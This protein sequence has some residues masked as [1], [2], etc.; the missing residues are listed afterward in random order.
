MVCGGK[1]VISQ[2]AGA[3]RKVVRAKGDPPFRVAPGDHLVHGLTGDD[4]VKM[5]DRRPL[6][7]DLD[8]EKPLHEPRAGEPGDPL[9]RIDIYRGQVVRAQIA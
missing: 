6:D 1:G 8:D 3:R 2:R 9:P 7:P 5:A 4:M